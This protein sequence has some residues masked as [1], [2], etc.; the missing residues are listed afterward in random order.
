M[1]PL[2]AS[3][4]VKHFVRK[5]RGGSQPILVQAA[6]GHLY[7]MKF[8]NNPQ[9]RNLLFNEAMGS[10]LYDACNL[11][12]SPWKPL[13]VTDQFLNQNQACWIQRP[14][15]QLRP[16]PGLCF[17]SR[18]LGKE[19]R[20]LLEIL[21]SFTFGRVSNLQDFWLAWVVDI[22]AGHTDNRQAVF[23]QQD[24][25]LLRA[26][27]IDHGNMFGGPNG[28]RRLHFRGSGYLDMRIYNKTNVNSIMTSSRRAFNLN[29]DRLW[30]QINALPEEWKT[31]SA[32]ETFATCLE[33]LANSQ[34]VQSVLE[35][36]V[37][38]SQNRDYRES[39]DLP[40]KRRLQSSVLRPGVPCEGPGRIAVA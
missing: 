27:F 18:Y 12:V 16:E 13:L 39:I 25:G 24:N 11:P 37:E 6:D 35:S 32:L 29:A 5:L 28:D 9:G 33:T 8:A 1:D 4:P 21:P 36:I 40:C 23:E 17:G 2:E 20:R 34:R 15:G 38:F 10:E 19:G 31:V 3:I 26:I 30:N 14:E 7:V 22:C